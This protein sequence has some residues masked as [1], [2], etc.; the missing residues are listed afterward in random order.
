MSTSIHLP[1]LER[2][3][4]AS[5]CPA[6]WEDMAGDERV[7]LCAECNLNVHDLSAMSRDEA[8]GVLA[9]LAE[10]RVCARFYRRADGT[11]LTQDCP[12]GLS[13][14][15]QR[16]RRA[17]LR[18]AMLFGLVGVAGVAAAATSESPW[19]ARVRLR[20]LKPFATVCEW[21]APGAPPVIVP[22]M[23]TGGI[24]CIPPSPLATNPTSKSSA[25]PNGSDGGN[26]PAPTGEGHQHE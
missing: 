10:G 1:L 6:R 15:R 22:R 12:V 18:V 19:G 16:M 7:R 14:A 17:V 13:K 4:I 2:V 24:V 9:T 3:Q 21:I 8:E 25:G 11:I 5:P 23:A 26:A 20:A